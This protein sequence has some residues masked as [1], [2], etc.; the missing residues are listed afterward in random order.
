[1]RVPA[2]AGADKKDAIARV[3]NDIS[4]ITKGNF[5]FFALLW[6][7]GKDGIQGIG[8]TG[9]AL[10]GSRGVV[11]V[12]EQSFVAESGGV[13][14]KEARKLEAEESLAGALGPKANSGLAGYGIV[15]VD[16][17]VDFVLQR[18]KSG[19]KRRGSRQAVRTPNVVEVSAVGLLALAEHF[20]FVASLVIDEVE[21]TGLNSTEG[22]GEVRAM[23]IRKCV[24]E[25]AQGMSRRSGLYG[26]LP[27]VDER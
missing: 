20:G 9:F 17:G 4:V 13:Y 25:K 6:N 19:R 1:V 14:S 3:A 7:A 24:E 18:A 8:A 11:G 16:G 21:Y 12:S 10:F 2:F 23:R 5:E 22:G 26:G 27:E 15:L